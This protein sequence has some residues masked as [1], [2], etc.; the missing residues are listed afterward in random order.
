MEVNKDTISETMKATG[1]TLYEQVKKLL[2]AGNIRTIIIKNKNDKEIAKFPL[3]A[4]V[5]G[6]AIL[7]VVAVIALVIGFANDC[8]IVVEKEP[9]TPQ[10]KKPAK[11][12][13]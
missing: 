8:S 5:I 12:V 7:P 6:A 3:T 4:G 10:S 13:E 9:E 2:H 11:R 1:K